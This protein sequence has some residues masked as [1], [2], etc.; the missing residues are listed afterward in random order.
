VREKRS[1]RDLMGQKKGRSD[2]TPDQQDQFDRL[3]QQ[4]ERYRG[5]GD[6]QLMEEI[7]KLMQDNTVRSKVQ[8]GELD[9]FADVIGPMLNAQQKQKLHQ[10]TQWLRAKQ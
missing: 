4:S 6:D 7:G 10:I 8:N 1:L 2:L 3:R 5:M 9:R